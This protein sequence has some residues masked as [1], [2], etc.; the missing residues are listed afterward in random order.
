M[1]NKFESFVK[2][3]AKKFKKYFKNFTN[4]KLQINKIF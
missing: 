2:A 4:A 1:L 3:T